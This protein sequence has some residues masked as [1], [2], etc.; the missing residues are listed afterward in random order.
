MNIGAAIRKTRQM[1]G[2]TLEQVALEADTFAGNLSKI[3]RAQQLPSLELLHKLAEALQIKMSDLYALA[4]G[5][6]SRKEDGIE[7]DENEMLLMRRQFLLLTPA[8]RR[9][10]LELLKVVRN[11][12]CP[13]AR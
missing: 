4:E 7:G 10:A 13:E 6:D 3:E 11:S 5:A 2:L 1:Q 12:Q 8:N 9:M